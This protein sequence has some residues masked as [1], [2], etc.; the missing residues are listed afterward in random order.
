MKPRSTPLVRLGRLARQAATAVLYPELCPGCARRLADPEGP[1]LCPSCLRDVPP[2]PAE[3]P[4]ERLAALAEAP[5]LASLQALWVYDEHGPV[6]RLQRSLKY[7]NAPFLGRRLG[8]LLAAHL[9]GS[10]AATAEVVVPVPLAQRRSL[11]RGYNQAGALAAGLADALGVAAD[12]QALV[13]SRATRSQIS[14]ARPRRWAN[15][16]G[17]F[18]CPDPAA[19]RG[20]TVLLVD[21]VLTTGATLAASALPLLEAGATVHGVA[22]ALA[23]V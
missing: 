5:A 19:F 15:V 14:L 11:E 9:D 1:P 7:G 6:G 22:L 13:R 10:A 20:R 21:D 8:G 12:P 17:A 16:A 4:A 2:A 23:P 3:E 18:A